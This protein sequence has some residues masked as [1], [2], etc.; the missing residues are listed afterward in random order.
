MRYQWRLIL[1]PPMSGKDN[2]EKDLELMEEVATG[3]C[4]PV[5]R[6]YRWSPPAVSLG[7]FQDENE[8]VDLEACREAGVDIV[9][10]PTGGRAVLHHQE[11]TYSIIV[12][13]AHPFIHKGGVLDAYRAIS[14][15]VI[16]AFNLLDICASVTPEEESGAGISPGSCF[17]TPSAYEIKVDGRKVV[18]SAQL[19]R[20]G[21]VLQ[22]GAILFKLPL[23]LYRRVLKSDYRKAESSRQME[24]GEKAAGLIDLGY[25]ISYDRMTRALVKGFSMVIPA[26]FASLRTKLKN[27]GE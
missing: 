11:L 16:T 26:V 3:D 27:K 14:R 24:L 25:E 10:R 19:R 18:G 6:I 7:Y 23:D 8:V 20:E 4:P 5:L 15:G 1:D 13:E 22:H 2:M 9:R 12:P 17:D 21:I